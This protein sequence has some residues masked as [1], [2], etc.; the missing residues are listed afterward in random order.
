MSILR[1]F[2]LTVLG[3]NKY[4][5]AKP[6]N[7]TNTEPITVIF[8]LETRYISTN[9]QK[10]FWGAPPKITPHFLDFSKKSAT[11][12]TRFFPVGRNFGHRFLKK[13]PKSSIFGVPDLENF[14][15]KIWFKKTCSQQKLGSGASPSTFHGLF[16]KMR[17]SDFVFCRFLL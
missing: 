5:Q 12:K 3:Q 6:R 16:S 8:L 2:V 17:F 4:S 7:F 14:F 10:K 15:L 11:Q 13:A 9:L 1:V